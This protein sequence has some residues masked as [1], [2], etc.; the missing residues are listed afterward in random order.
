[1]YVFRLN[2]RVIFPRK[3]HHDARPDYSPIGL[4]G[5]VLRLVFAIPL[6][7]IGSSYCSPLQFTEILQYFYMRQ[8]LLISSGLI[9]D[10]LM[11]PRSS[12]DFSFIVLL[13][14]LDFFITILISFFPDTPRRLS[15]SSLSGQARLMQFPSRNP[16]QQV[17]RRSSS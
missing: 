16:A 14:F 15:C 8:I 4:L 6:N 11:Q 17:G 3:R 12:E 5:W 13:F 9:F 10:F 1:M 2:T 7:E